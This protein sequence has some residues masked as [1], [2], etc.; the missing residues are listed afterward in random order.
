MT[1]AAG[2]LEYALARMHARLGRRPPE[3]AWR[4]IEQSRDIAPILDLC[5]E[6]SLQSVVKELPAPCDL[7]SVDH[8]VRLGWRRAVDEALNW[9]PPDYADAL[10]WCRLV[11]LLPALAH[12]A[13]GG[14][15]ALWMRTE[16]DLAELSAAPG[17]QRAAIVAHGRLAPLS[18][19]WQ[20][21]EF[22]AEAWTAEWQRRLPP[23]ALEDTALASLARELERHLEHFQDADTH[24][25]PEL[26]RDLE[27]HLLATFRR[28]PLD[29]A[30]VFA[31]LGLTALDLERLRGELARRL[32]FPRARLVT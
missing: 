16:P 23:E 22:L 24:E 15:P 14:D 30:A 1:T 8:A 3:A 19:V 21:P 25:A 27:S 32:A 6:T 4:S 12:L 10:Q 28:N 9:M 31:W 2:S 11:P 20:K 7:H 26:R 17:D 18:I 5:R 13:R 29:S